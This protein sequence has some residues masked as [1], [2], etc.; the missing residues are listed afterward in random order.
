MNKTIVWIVVLLVLGAG[1]YWIAT[2]QKATAPVVFTPTE[3]NTYNNST[4]GI[5]FNY[6]KGYVL[7][8][9][10]KGNAE[11]MHY[12]IVLVQ[13]ADAVLP[14]NGEGPTAITIDIYQNNLDKLSLLD[15]LNGTAVSNFKLGDGT[16]SSTT[17]GG[18]EAVSY[19]WSGLYE[20]E[21]TAFLHKDN[22]VAVSVTRLTPEDT[23]LTDYQEL[24]S[25]VQLSE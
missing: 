18:K 7:S 25:S 21:T 16:Y 14:Q 24:L 20:G 1:I 4:Y 3:K 13:E 10:E 15:W 22:I 6:P 11:R 12:A 19:A 17:V 2:T 9:G 23:I 5:A 8:E